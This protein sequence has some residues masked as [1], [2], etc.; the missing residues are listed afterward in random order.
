M[1]AMQ[2]LE[3]DYFATATGG[4]PVRSADRS[5]KLSDE[6][7]AAY[8]KKMSLLEPM[9]GLMSPTN[10]LKYLGIGK[11]EKVEP[12]VTDEQREPFPKYFSS[13]SLTDIVGRTVSLGKDIK[14]NR[15]IIL[16]E[17]MNGRMSIGE[18]EWL[19]WNRDRAVTGVDPFEKLAKKIKAVADAHIAVQP[20]AKAKA[21]KVRY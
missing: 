21:P 13:R 1:G 5:V 19:K 12:L 4:G 9:S 11:P 14:T 16:V 3:H 17:G 2:H 18:N 10:A 15:I 6:E 7:L 8:I 20:K